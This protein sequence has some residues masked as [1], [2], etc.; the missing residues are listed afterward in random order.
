MT[1]KILRFDSI[2][3]TNLEA[4][5]QAKAG[6]SEGLCVIAREQ[7]QG[8]GRLDRRW[9]SPKDAGLYLSILLR[10]PFELSKWPLITLAAALAVSDA[11][12]KSYGLAIDVKWPNDICFDD[13]KLC[14]ILAETVETETG[15]AAV[16]G[17][18]INLLAEAVPEG[19]KGRATSIESISDQ[20]IDPNLLIDN[21]VKAFAAR[22]QVLHD[23]DGQEHTLREWCANS[24]Y[25][26]G[27]SVR[28]AIGDDGFTGVTRGLESDGALRVEMADGKV[29]IVRAGDVTA[30]RAVGPE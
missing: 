19:L 25:A 17:I 29:R 23:E 1:P 9:H 18:G 15:T 30:L 26:F 8:R 4:M 21:V 24:S 11:I 20:R 5:R 14:G 2:D 7:T 16:V 22:Y 6:A 3:S 12:T 27:R 10:P 13:Q 28:V